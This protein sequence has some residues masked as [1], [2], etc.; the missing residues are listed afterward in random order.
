MITLYGPAET[1]FTEKVRRALLYKGIEFELVEPERPEDYKRLSP[2][3]GQLPVLDLHGEHVPDSTEILLRLDQ[4]YPDPPLL[5]PDP[6]V[7]E[8]QRQLEEWADESFLWYFMK[9]R[10]MA[11]GDQ[12]AAPLP[13]AGE[14]GAPPPLPKRSSSLRRLGAWLKAGGTWERPHTALLRELALRLD[15]LANFLGARPF[16]YAEQLS[17]ADLAV[18]SMLLYLREDRIPGASLLLAARPTLVAL[19]ERVEA[20][21]GGRA[22]PFSA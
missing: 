8:Q 3:T 22:G 2:K 18:Y 13:V 11:M 6:T 4:A 21:S 12:Y 9:Y 5:S 16:F 19:L 20:A 14:R 15:D 10:R 17:M 7:A 1:P